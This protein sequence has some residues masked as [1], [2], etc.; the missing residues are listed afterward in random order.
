MHLT[1]SLD[2]GGLESVVLNLFKK[3]DRSY[4]HPMVCSLTKRTALTQEFEEIGVPVHCL[5]KQADGLDYGLPIRLYR[6]LI[7]NQID[8]LHTHNAGPLFYGLLAK[9]LTRKV[10][11]VHTQH[12]RFTSQNRILSKILWFLSRGY[13]QIVCDSESVASH[14]IAVTGIPSSH[15]TTVYNG[16]DTDLYSTATPNTALLA[17]VGIPVEAKVIGTVGRLEDEKDYPMLLTAFQKLCQTEKNVYLVI[18]GYGSLEQNLKQMAQDLFIADRV[19]FLGQRRNI[20][21]ILPCFDLFV[22]SSQSEGFPLVIL[23]AMAARVPIL[24][25]NVGGIPEMIVDQESGLLTTPKDADLMAM[26]MAT[27]LADL[28]A[29][30]ERSDAAFTKVVQAFSL[31]SMTTQYEA[32]YRNL[33][34]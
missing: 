6:L 17:E 8:I 23:E 10:K 32:I 33:P 13:D 21:R 28:P 12:S 25:T 16:I 7:A 15:I 1:F 26:K 27:V 31:E 24:T 11:L 19:I 18:V 22:L 30:K 14:C 34:K 2:L 5:N 9:Q 20:H 3:I 29:A 4:Y